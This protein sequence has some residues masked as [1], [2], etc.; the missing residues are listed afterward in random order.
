MVNINNGERVYIDPL[1]K[2]YID[3]ETKTLAEKIKRETGLQKITI[4]FI[5]ST[6]WLANRLLNNKALIK[7]RVKKVGLNE[8]VVE[9]I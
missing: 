5:S 9:F 4:P 6:G 8:G 2:F 7:Y 3:K 1:M